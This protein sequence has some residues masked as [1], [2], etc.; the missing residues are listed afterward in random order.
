MHNFNWTAHWTMHTDSIRLTELSLFVWSGPGC[1]F[2]VEIGWRGG[3]ASLHL[4]GNTERFQVIDEILQDVHFVGRHVVERYSRVRTAIQSLI[5]S[6]KSSVTY[7]CIVTNNNVT[8]INNKKKCS[9]PWRDSK[10]TSNTRT[11]CWRDP[12]SNGVLGRKGRS[13]RVRTSHASP[14]LS[15]P[16]S[17]YISL[18]IWKDTTTTATEIMIRTWQVGNVGFYP[19]QHLQRRRD[20]CGISYCLSIPS[21]RIS[22][23]LLYWERSLVKPQK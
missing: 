3:R 16:T 2:Q 15:L 7:T 20:R 19:F 10:C 1:G 21:R 9:P 8:L 18:T 4:A 13:G 6:N 14:S 23:R 11:I 12:V 22:S 17:P 5:L